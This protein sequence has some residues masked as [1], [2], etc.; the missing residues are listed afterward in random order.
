M[1][2]W[3]QLFHWF[4]TTDPRW[5]GVLK[6][7]AVKYLDSEGLIGLNS[8]N[9]LLNI[10]YVIILNHKKIIFQNN[11]PFRPNLGKRYSQN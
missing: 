2:I 11:E 8:I 4:T 1:C 5:T 6:L 10:I 3:P 7:T 9:Y